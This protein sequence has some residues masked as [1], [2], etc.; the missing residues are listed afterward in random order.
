MGIV[1]KCCFVGKNSLHFLDLGQFVPGH[2]L[3][4]T[5]AF[6]LKFKE[7]YYNPPYQYTYYGV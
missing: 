3:S 2:L 1:K 7:L 6:P 4:V 5:A